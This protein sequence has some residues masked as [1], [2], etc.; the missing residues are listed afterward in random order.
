MMRVILKRFLTG[1]LMLGLVFLVSQGHAQESGMESDLQDPDM[2]EPM[3]GETAAAEGPQE[4]YMKPDLESMN[5][6]WL[7]EG[8]VLR[9][10][11]VVQT[12]DTM[13]DIAAKYLN[14]PYYWP[15]IWERNSKVVI[16]PHLIYPGDILYLYPEV[17]IQEEMPTEEGGTVYT[18][19]PTEKREIRYQYMGSTG[20]VSTDELETSGKIIDNL[21]HKQL[22]GEG[23]KVYVNLGKTGYKEE[24]DKLTAIRLLRDAGTGEVIAVHHPVTGEKIGY[25][26]VHLGIIELTNVE[27]E[28][29]EAVIAES[30]IEITNGDRLISYTEPLEKK[31]DVLPTSIKKLKGYVIASKS[32][33]QLMGNNDI[34]YLDVGTNDNVKRGHM[35]YIYEPCELIKDPVSQD[36]VRIPKKIIGKAVILDPK[37][38][39]S[40]ALITESNKEIQIGERVIMSMYERWEIEGV[41]KSTDVESCKED[42]RCELITEEEYE[43]GTVSPFC[44]VI[45]QEELEEREEEKK[46][47]R[48]KY[49]FK[50]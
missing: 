38:N 10:G 43:N 37:P 28:V 20:F 26:V 40:V 36:Y 15:K 17:V 11:Y 16:N 44:T 47:A 30:F 32:R 25:Q 39:T 4:V 1:A 27:A 21:Q 23:D 18:P 29:S 48:E 41:S 45:S 34:V 22:L 14:S 19:P 8:N 42:P 31:L 24:G 46:G 33:K 9:V 3:A 12:G 13:W 7:Q 35:F 6:I 50:E 49:R 5:L 2:M